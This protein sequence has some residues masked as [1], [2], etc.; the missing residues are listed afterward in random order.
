MGIFCKIKLLPVRNDPVDFL[1]PAFWRLV[2]RVSGAPSLAIREWDILR[3]CAHLV[4]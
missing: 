4:N 2:I 3:A 1:K